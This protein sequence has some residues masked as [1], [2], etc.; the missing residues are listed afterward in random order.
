M[1]EFMLETWKL[2]RKMVKE[3]WSAKL[4]PMMDIGLTARNKV[5]ESSL[6]VIKQLLTDIGMPMFSGKQ[7]IGTT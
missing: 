1:K 4:V 2:V 7:R 3:S 5:L 6:T